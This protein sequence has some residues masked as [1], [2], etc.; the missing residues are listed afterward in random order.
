MSFCSN[1]GERLDETAQ[2][3]SKCG[4]EISTNSLL[5]KKNTATTYDGKIYKCP[6]CGEIL[7]AFQLKCSSC[8]YEIRSSSESQALSDFYEKLN[9]AKDEGQ[10]IEIIKNFPIP[11]TKE[12]LINFMT[13]AV[14]NYDGDYAA[15]HKYDNDIS[16]AYFAVAEKCF[17][18]AKML[19]LANS[20][21]MRCIEEEYK[22]MCKERDDCNK[23]QQ[24]KENKKRTSDFFKTFTAS[25]SSFF[26]GI[27]ITPIFV[28]C[29]IGFLAI[30]LAVLIPLFYL[31]ILTF[32]KN[33][34]SV[35][36]DSKQIITKDISYVIENLEDKGFT[37]IETRPLDWNYQYKTN[38][39]MSI[40]ID[41][42]T[43]F[44]EGSKFD[45]SAKIVIYYNDAPQM[46]SIGL[47]S[48]EIIGKDYKHIVK[49]LKDLGFVYFET[50]PYDEFLS[51]RHNRIK[52]IVIDKKTSF[53][54]TDEFS[55]DS[56]IL[57]IYYNNFFYE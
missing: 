27:K 55:Q 26:N 11:D 35:G 10:K 34:V 54:K 43:R 13:W 12:D 18:K 30:C 56:K 51:T 22:A 45:K 52:E 1:C 49:L 3:C 23:N 8:G 4:K 31:N 17:Y 47:T 28:G 9:S 37:Y 41:G 53:S 5:T 29:S 40:T 2:S 38:A 25:I 33:A 24:K 39:T 50:N 32:N 19:F 36:L 48:S 21:E 7:N 42:K 14:S 15:M 20:S 6:N 46:V 44:V 16:D 57:I